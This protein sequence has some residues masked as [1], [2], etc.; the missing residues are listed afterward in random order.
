MIEIWIQAAGL[1]LA[2]ATLLAGSV[3]A[4]D[5]F[6]PR[7]LLRE[8][9]DLAVAVIAITPLIFATALMPQQAGSAEETAV[10]LHYP[11]VAA[12]TA[13][14]GP[15]AR[16][17]P[18]LPDGAGGDPAGG[19][20]WPA[21]PYHSIFGALLLVWILGSA[22][23]AVRLA[24][25]LAALRRLIGRARPFTP[26]ASL[27]LSRALPIAESPDV[28]CPMLAGFF[29]PVI[30]VPCGFRIDVSARAVLEHEIAHARRGDTWIALGLRLAMTVF[31]WA[32][33]LRLLQPVID[34]S[35]E[36][37]CDRQAAQ[38][39]GEPRALASALLDT[40]AAAVRTPSLALAAAPTR[41]GLARRIG[42]L[43]DPDTLARKDT[44]MRFALILP[45]LAAGTLAL[46]PNVGAAGGIENNAVPTR[47]LDT[48]LDL[49]ASLF[50]AAR[51][52]RT[53][54]IEE[55][56]A[57]GA[58]PDVAF[59][60]DGTALT[61]AARNG[62]TR[63]VEILLEAG[64]DPDLGSGGDGNP[65]IAAAARG[66][67]D[68]V[69]RLLAYGADVDSASP[70]DGNALI[71]AS[72]RGQTDIVNLLVEAGADP[73]G[74]V[75]GD[76]TPLINAAQQGHVDVAEILAE[77]GA[78]LSLTVLANIRNG[79]E[80]YRSPISEARRNGHRGMVA[81]LEARGATHN[82][83]SE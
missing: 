16:T 45:V 23:M 72:L 67:R 36:A 79:E 33:P 15:A 34:R 2:G 9:H 65:L 3:L 70:G 20:D 12:E 30:L 71:A 27:T 17:G 81:W 57:E 66:D 37:L 10:Y 47:T 40:A 50:Q 1:T 64:A 11:S 7:G 69:T 61:A 24:A 59:R 39:T 35:R 8:R 26:P 19:F 44:V 52:G 31:W 60:G 32:L 25:D 29:R 83:P 78:D 42:H 6:A 63:A 21:L 43:T 13:Q 18:R 48:S 53:G 58:N 76:E 5:R 28:A 56:L 62:H 82:P 75:R 49:D 77:A 46:T 80:I 51:R 54:W 73:N 14:T 38:I 22:A 74:Y 41:S 68:V 55:L 4:F